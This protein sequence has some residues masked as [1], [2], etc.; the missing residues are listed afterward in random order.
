MENSD[1]KGERTGD[2]KYNLIKIGKRF[3]PFLTGLKY[4]TL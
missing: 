4:L 1:T 3:H 2:N